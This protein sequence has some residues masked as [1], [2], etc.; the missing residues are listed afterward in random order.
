[1]GGLSPYVH[2]TLYFKL[3]LELSINCEQIESVT[4]EITTEKK[5][6]SYLAIYVELHRV[7]IPFL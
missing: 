2:K 1:M 7:N 4:I 5:I 3:K 6:I